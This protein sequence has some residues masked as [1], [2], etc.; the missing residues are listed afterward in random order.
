MVCE[1]FICFQNKDK[2]MTKHLV[3][4]AGN[5]GVGKFFVN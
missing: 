4:V 5:I 2:I 3:V 1:Q